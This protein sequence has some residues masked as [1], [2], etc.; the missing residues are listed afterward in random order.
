MEIPSFSDYVT[1]K[2]LDGDKVRID[3]ILNQEIVITG[4]N[5]SESKYKKGGSEICKKVHCKENEKE[6]F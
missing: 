2:T 6:I 5:V 1:D 3:D 4:Y